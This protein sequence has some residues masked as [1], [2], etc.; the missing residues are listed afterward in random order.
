MKQAI[1]VNDENVPMSSTYR[2]IPLYISSQGY[3]YVPLFDG[4]NDLLMSRGASMDEAIEYI[5][6]N[7]EPA[8]LAQTIHT[9]SAALSNADIDIESLMSK[10]AYLEAK[11]PIL[12]RK[13]SATRETR[14]A[15]IIMNERPHPHDATMHIV[16]GKQG[17]RYCTWILDFTKDG[18]T[19]KR[20]FDLYTEA[21]TDFEERPNGK[22]P[23]QE[24]ATPPEEEVLVPIPAVVD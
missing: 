24:P 8:N 13:L 21:V 10:K 14:G 23:A 18:F 4:D 7:L 19:A 5:N 2:G 3:V 20:Q 16:M 6:T 17:D 15:R 1:T 12:R 22:D 11:L 9:V